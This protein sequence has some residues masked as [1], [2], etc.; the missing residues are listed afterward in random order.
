MNEIWN[1]IRYEICWQKTCK[2]YQKQKYYFLA[3]C[4]TGPRPGSGSGSRSR[5]SLTKFEEKKSWSVFLTFKKLKNC[6][7]VRNNWACANLLYKKLYKVAVISK[8]LTFRYFLVDIFILLDPDPEP[9]IECW[10]VSRRGKWMRIHADPD[11]QPWVKQ[12]YVL[13]N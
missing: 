3:A 9:H 12:Q 4:Q 5:S 13:K 1:E 10:S 6:S 7:K 2:I 8:F 11:P